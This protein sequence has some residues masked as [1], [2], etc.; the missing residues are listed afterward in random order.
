M[1]G[2]GNGY[3]MLINNKE[4]SNEIDY[5]VEEWFVYILRPNFNS[6]I[7]TIFDLQLHIVYNGTQIVLEIPKFKGIQ[8]YGLCDFS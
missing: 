4:I 6:V 8:F 2:V 3:K 5:Y 1:D 7:L